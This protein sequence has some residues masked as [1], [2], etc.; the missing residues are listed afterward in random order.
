VL[1]FTLVTIDVSMTQI[2][3]FHW[4]ATSNNLFE[5]RPPQLWN[6]LLDKPIKLVPEVV[7]FLE[8]SQI[9]GSW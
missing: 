1:N 2:A 5:L 8:N 3:G 7:Q 4:N 6:D 9:G